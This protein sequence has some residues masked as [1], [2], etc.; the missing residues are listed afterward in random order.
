MKKKFLSLL[1]AVLFCLPVMAQ[2]L[3]KAKLDRYFEALETNNRFMGSVAV[4]R[5]GKIVYTKA[6]GFA[7]ADSRTKANTAS[8]Y[9]IGSISKTFTATLVM[10]AVEEK[11][12]KLDQTIDKW[13]PGLANAER[14]TVS[15]LLNHRSGIYN[16]TN[17]AAYLIWYTEPQTEAS[18]LEKIKAG[19]S[20]FEPNTKAEYSNAN[21]VLLTFILEKVFNK[22][23]SELVTTYITK[24]LGLKDT[25]VGSKINATKNEVRSYSF[26]DGVWNVDTETD[27]SVPLGAGAIVST[28]SDLVRFSDALF[29]EKIVSAASLEKMRTMTDDHGMGLF[30]FPFGEQKGYGH[31]GGIDA[32]SSVFVHFPDKEL[33]FALTSNG[34][35]YSNNDISIAVL[36]AINGLPYSVPEFRSI[37]LT[38]EELTPYLGIYTSSAIPLKITVSK[39]KNVLMAQ[40]TGQSAFPLE[41]IDTH[42]FEFTQAG[43]VLEFDPE[44]GR[45]TLKQGGGTFVFEKQ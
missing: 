2:D 6:V 44:T 19:G 38:E 16:F 5:S 1:S 20:D 34:G 26:E 27:M 24:P 36:S 10:K 29:G 35:T 9:R 3:D 40:A 15:N 31:T 37:K 30:L 39:N 25:Y 41:A 43:I 22:P 23:Y 28:P 33:S 14:I 45:M 12:V 42:V 21:Y 18:L 11:K 7:D 32:F 4:S 17:S 8:K 13:F